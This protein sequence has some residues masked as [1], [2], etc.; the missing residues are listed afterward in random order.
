MYRVIKSDWELNSE[1]PSV[2][3]LKELMIE[4]MDKQDDPQVGIFWYDPQKHEL[5]GV[6][7][8]DPQ[9]V[10]PH[11]SSLFGK[12]V[13]TCTP[14]HYKVWDKEHYRG[15]DDR[16]NGDYTLTPRGRVF[17]VEDEGFVVIVGDWIKKYP[18]AKDLIEF[19]FNLPEDV[20]YQIDP[21]WNIGHGGSDKFM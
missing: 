19:E 11:I 16:F 6:R 2:N 14:L 15:K 13:R 12:Q 3:A 17:Y 10:Q 4:N 5:F 8:A 20:K 18:R 7:S 21:H 1:D 9:D